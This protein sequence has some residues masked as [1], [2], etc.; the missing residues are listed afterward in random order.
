MRIS[1]WSSD[2]CSSDLQVARQ[3]EQRYALQA[4]R[5]PLGAR[6]DQGEPGVGVRAEPLVAVQPPGVDRM[7]VVNGK[8]VSRRVDLVG[9]TIITQKTCIK[10]KIYSSYYI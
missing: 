5:R 7:R 10:R 9:R 6:Q 8:S 2:V 1:D 4:R 3:Q